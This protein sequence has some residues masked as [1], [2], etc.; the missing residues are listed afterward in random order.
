MSALKFV[1]IAT[2]QNAIFM[3]AEDGSVYTA[4]YESKGDQSGGIMRHRQILGEFGTDFELETPNI[5][6][7]LDSAAKTAY[8]AFEAVAE[9]DDN[10][11]LTFRFNCPMPLA[12]I[13]ILYDG[14]TKTVPTGGEQFATVTADYLSV[15]KGDG[16]LVYAI[17][18]G[19]RVSD[20]VKVTVE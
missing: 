15:E 1:G 13:G 7:E 2:N 4:T 6:R 10:D 16:M 17:R 8:V 9:I 18:D 19:R 11:A 3:L 20:Y 14:E 5:K 12:Y